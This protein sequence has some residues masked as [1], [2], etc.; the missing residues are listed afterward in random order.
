MTTPKRRILSLVF[1]VLCFMGLL[2]QIVYMRKL[3]G[4]KEIQATRNGRAW[5]AQLVRSLSSDHKVPS[6]IPALL[7]FETFVRPSFPPKLTEL[8]IPASGVGK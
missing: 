6:S 4:I 2:K 8:S 3:K 5:L 1:T 7:R